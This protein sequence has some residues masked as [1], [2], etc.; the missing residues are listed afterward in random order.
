ML[1]ISEKIQIGNKV[2]IL[3]PAY[4]AGKVGV[5]CG[6]EALLRSQLSHRWLIRVDFEEM[7][8]SLT[9]KEFLLLES[10]KQIQHDA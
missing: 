7:V 6:Q 8:V 9:P 1:H 3:H 5:V 2:F 10:V 4:V